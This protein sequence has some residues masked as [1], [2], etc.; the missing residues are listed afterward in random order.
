MIYF[1]VIIAYL[2]ILIGVGAYRSKYVRTQDDFMV[3]GR[4]LSTRVLIGTLLATWIGSGSIIAGAGLSYDRGLP[5]LWFHAGVWTAL[6]ILYFVAGRARSFAQYTVPDILEVRYNKWARVLG[7]IVTVIAYTAIVS[8]QFRAGGMVLNLITGIPVDQGIIITAVF[9]IGYTVLAGLISVAYTDVVNGIIMVLGLIIAL[10]FLLSNAGGWSGVVSRLPESHFTVLGDMTI[11]KALGYSLPAM[12]LLL[13]ESGMYQR[14][15]SAKDERAAKRSVIG[16]I[17]GT[18]I[19]EF[20]I[21]IIAVVGS[22][23]FGDIE[24]EMVILYA[25]RHGLP[26]VIGC[27]CL[28]AIVAVIVST[29]D[30]F[31][32]VPATNLMR[33]IYQRFINPNLPQKK[34]V[35]YSRIVVVLLGGFAFVQV[36]FFERVLEMAIYAYTMYGVGITPA[37]MAAFFWKRATPAAG[38]C[39]IASGMI[40]TIV[41]EVLGQPYGLGTVYP[42]LGLSL[43][44]LIFISLVSPRPDENKWKPFFGERTAGA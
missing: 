29:A 36:R 19:I 8:Y 27:L 7:T 16:W 40:V 24:S 10:P 14:F 33:D 23:L 6:F 9:V 12:L 1:W 11:W 35:L 38:V 34:M 41:W 18:I 3:A 26:I 37:V 44:S 32:L 15:F 42:A 28:A 20:L 4:K 2:V 5:A 25:V 13:G 39:S 30:S 21:V 17:T 31:L 43:F 22:S